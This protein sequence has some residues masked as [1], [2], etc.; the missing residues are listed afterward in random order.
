[1]LVP[2]L[3]SYLCDHHGVGIARTLGRL[4]VPVYAII[5]NRYTPMAVSRYLAGAFVWDTAG[6]DDLQLLDGLASIGRQL[7]RPT[8]VIP[9]DDLTAISFAKLSSALKPWFLLPPQ[10]PELLRLVANKIEM[11]RLCNTMEVPCPRW[12]YPQSI[13]EVQSFLEQAKLPVIL[14]SGEAWRLPAAMRRAR[15]IYSSKQLLDFFAGSGLATSSDLLLQEYIPEEHAEHWFYHGY[16]D[17]EANPRAGFTGRKLRSYPPFAGVTAAGVAVLN[18][19]LK[20]EA[21]SLLRRISYSGVV[22][23][24]YIFDKRYGSYNLIDFN[25]RVGAQF[26]L[27]EDDAG[28][29][30]IRACYFD[31]TGV[32]FNARLQKKNRLFVLEPNDLISGFYYLWFRRTTIRGWLRSLQGEREMAWFSRDDPL[33]FLAMILRLL[34]SVAE[35][36][37]GWVRRTSWCR[38]VS[39]RCRTPRPRPSDLRNGRLR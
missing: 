20:L 6:I 19:T 31:L 15:I 5:E 16:F 2:K 13:D 39:R 17:A 30:V 23:I 4:G 11:Y 1:V 33:P 34:L 14:K 26:R 35:R 38:A 18:N 10:S 8:V 32:R 21:E 12:T 29:D 3:G 24:D 28:I 7:G 36:I 27:L 9:I 37:T 22:D 25:P